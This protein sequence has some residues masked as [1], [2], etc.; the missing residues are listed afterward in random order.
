[1]L[2]YEVGSGEWEVGSGE[3]RVASQE[4]GREGGRAFFGGCWTNI[5]RN[6]MSIFEK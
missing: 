4:S 2:D 6:T 5:W 1:M 3:W